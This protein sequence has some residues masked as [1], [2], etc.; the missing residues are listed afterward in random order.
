MAKYLFLLFACLSNSI[1]AQMRLTEAQNE[2]IGTK[3]EEL[4]ITDFIQNTPVDTN[5]KNKFR[6]LEFWA[7]WCKPCL[8]A[9]P[10]LNKLN[11]KF[12][13][14]NIVFLS[15]THESPETAARILEKVKFK[16]IV[17]SDQTKTIHRNLR[18]EY[19]GTMV[20]PRTVLVDDENN[21]V[22]YGYPDQLTVTRIRK[23]LKKE[24]L[25]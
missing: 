2:L 14:D 8:S 22:W 18:I 7:T 3:V 16:T 4:K 17:V 21:I 20:I 1:Y 13:D 23:F 6:V 11:E 24:K 15:V 5:F 19:N 12:K 25:K 9:I 10:H